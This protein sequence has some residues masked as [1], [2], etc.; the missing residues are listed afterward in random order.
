MIDPLFLHFR[1]HQIDA[2]RKTKKT[3]RRKTAACRLF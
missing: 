2:H 1:L 3:K